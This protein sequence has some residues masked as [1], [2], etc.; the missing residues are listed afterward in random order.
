MTNGAVLHLKESLI[1]E[2]VAARVL[3]FATNSCLNDK[4]AIGINRD[5]LAKAYDLIFSQK[6]KLSRN[7]D[8]K[9]CFRGDD[10]IRNEVSLLLFGIPLKN[11]R[12]KEERL[13][14]DN[15]VASAAFDVPAADTAQ[16]SMHFAST[17]AQLK[18]TNIPYTVKTFDVPDESAFD[19]FVG[20]EDA[21][22]TID[23]QVK[24]AL[25]RGDMLRNIL[26]RG[27]SGV[28]KTELACRI[29]KRMGK[30]FYIVAG[31]SLKSSDDVDALINIVS[32]DCIVFIDEI[33]SAGDK[34]Q[35]RLLTVMNK[36]SSNGN[37]VTFILATNL[38]GKLLN[39]ALRNRCLELKLNDYSPA[40]LQQI[41]NKTAK[42]NGVELD[43]GVANYIAKRC[44]GI[45]R[46]AVYYTKDV[47]VEDVTDH[48]IVTMQHV[49]SFFERR[50]I[51]SAGLSAEHR[52]YI[53]CLYALGQA[54]ALSLAAALAE[55]DVSEVEKS[56]EPLL[57]KEGLITIGSRGRS[58]TDKGKSYAKTV[59]E[60][61]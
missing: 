50:G 2:E 34:A 54:S 35:A 40:E 30:N 12:R 5:N 42:E 21:V 6:D 61:F 23:L 38:S 43:D 44:H 16:K 7:A 17:P 46:N 22:M 56:I 27:V 10:D 24:G 55:N 33:Q 25:L 47:V 60:E 11:L 32:N 19:G 49:K 52:R 26:L 58:L 20:N 8:G 28:G 39:V 3:L 1:K 13:L 15:S 9:R 59:E 18:S 29:A 14:A 4:N 51:D 53:M 57:L 45:A 36:D 31:S 41:I 48:G 37:E